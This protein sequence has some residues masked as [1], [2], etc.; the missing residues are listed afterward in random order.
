MFWI[1]VNQLSIAYKLRY[2]KFSKFVFS[3]KNQEYLDTTYF[4]FD[5]VTTDIKTSSMT[6]CIMTLKWMLEYR[7]NQDKCYCCILCPLLCTIISCY[8]I[9]IYYCKRR[10]NSSAHQ[11]AHVKKFV[12]VALYSNRYEFITS[13]EI[14]LTKLWATIRTFIIMKCTKLLLYDIKP[15]IFLL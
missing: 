12:V 2:K 9:Y 11:S 7:L 1:Q 3:L 14:V 4:W 6:Y 5:T 13:F 8:V 10:I 15:F